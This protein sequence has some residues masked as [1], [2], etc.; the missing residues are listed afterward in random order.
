MNGSF[1]FLLEI[2]WEYDTITKSVRNISDAISYLERYRSGHNEPH[3]KCGRPFWARGFESHSLRPITLL[4]QWG[5]PF[6]IIDV[7]TAKSIIHNSDAGLIYDFLMN[8]ASFF[9]T[10]GNGQIV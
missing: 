5:F 4:I 7:F 10:L 8:Y 9:R 3:S 1:D 2:R 6:L